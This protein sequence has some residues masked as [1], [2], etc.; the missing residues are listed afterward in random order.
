MPVASEVNKSRKVPF[1]KYKRKLE[2]GLD[3][4]RNKKGRGISNKKN[5]GRL[6]DVSSGTMHLRITENPN[7]MLKVV[8]GQLWCNACKC[9]CNAN[10]DVTEAEINRRA[11]DLSYV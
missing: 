7:N 3:E 9:K 5:G 10:G 6:N 2:S 8:A 11:D 4:S 1:S